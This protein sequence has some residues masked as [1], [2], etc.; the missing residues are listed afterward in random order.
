MY[1]PG[2]GEYEYREG[3]GQVWVPYHQYR[4][5][6]SEVAGNK[7]VVRQGDSWESIAGKLTG[8]QRQFL[9]IAKV[10]PNIYSLLPGMVI[11]IPDIFPEDPVVPSGI[12]EKMGYA[13]TGEIAAWYADPT[14]VGRMPSAFTTQQVATQPTT[15]PLDILGWGA[16]ERDTYGYPPGWRPATGMAPGALQPAQYPPGWRPAKISEAPG[17]KPSAWTT[18]SLRN[19]PAFNPAYAARSSVA[20]TAEGRQREVYGQQ[21][22]TGDVPYDLA[23]ML[24]GYTPQL[25]YDAL[26]Q[27]YPS[28]PALTPAQQINRYIESSKLLNFLRTG[29]WATSGQT[30]VVPSALGVAPAPTGAAL[31]AQQR[32]REREMARI[33]GLTGMIGPIKS[34]IQAVSDGTATPSQE[35]RVAEYF[36]MPFV[37][38]A[39]T[40]PATTPYLY[41]NPY[42]SGGAGPDIERN[43]QLWG[44]VIYT[45][46]SEYADRIAETPLRDSGL[47]SG[48][49][50]WRAGW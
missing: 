4:T 7:Y 6:G 10:N 43:K 18:A 37:T 50:T 48:L 17:L 42:Y 45:N 40:T 23:G 16:R 1:E 3:R 34:D 28:I 15:Q 32:E 44:N 38:P 25:L 22:P 31:P 8:N 9:E 46:A 39:T 49:F 20:Q 2:T 14:N 41:A 26:A 12:V 27:K 11:N 33:G 21:A 35:A 5:P 19:A 13:T 36:G 30:G 47:L 29:Q 24:P